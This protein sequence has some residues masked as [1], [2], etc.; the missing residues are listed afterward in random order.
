VL[1][2]NIGTRDAAAAVTA[3]RREGFPSG[4]IVFLDQEQGGHMLPEQRAY[5][6][7]WID[8]II[9]AGFR[10]G[11]YCSG[12]A[13]TENGERGVVTAKD[14]R[15]GAD[16]RTISFFVYNDACPTSPG[17]AMLAK[18][19]PPSQ[20]GVSFATVWQYAQSP[21]RPEY[22]SQCSK[23]YDPDGNCY[24][25]LFERSNAIEVDVSS[26]MSP[27]PSSGRR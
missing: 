6:H 4:A 17:C 9:A 22:T 18:P 25:P 21:R 15:D 16:G 1:A 11:I 7:S 20:S 26:A 27:D 23:H 5:L 13:A 8:G 12:I 24:A 19:L 3:A 10:A 2:K 14:I